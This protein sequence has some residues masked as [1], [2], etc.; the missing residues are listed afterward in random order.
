MGQQIARRL[1]EAG[2][3]GPAAELA[4]RLPADYFGALLGVLAVPLLVYTGLF[5]YAVLR[6]PTRYPRWIVL[7]TPTLLFVV[8]HI[9]EYLVPPTS[10]PLYAAYAVLAGGAANLGLLVF[11]TAATIALWH[12]GRTVTAS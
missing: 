4:T 2:Q 10:G 9:P 1:D 5:V 6:R 3:H 8:T 7:V 12:G 11:F